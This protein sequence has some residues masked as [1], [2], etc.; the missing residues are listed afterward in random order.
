MEFFDWKLLGEYAG[1]VM[2]VGILTELT[3]EIPGI[4]AIP[5]QLWSYLLALVTLLL[6]QAFGGGLTARGAVLTLFNAAVVS[7]S[8][9]GGYSAAKRMQMGTTGE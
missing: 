8:A 1:A 5:T 3:K 6:A 2:A 4:K 7:L 9:N